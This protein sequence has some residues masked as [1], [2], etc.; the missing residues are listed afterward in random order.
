VA[1]YQKLQLEPT[2]TV[3]LRNAKITYVQL[4]KQIQLMVE[5]FSYEPR[6]RA[7]NHR[8]A[9]RFKFLFKKK[10]GS[11]TRF[12]RRYIIFEIA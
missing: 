5:E 2:A 12:K 4:S 6:G 11:R 1:F 3:L 7:R 10:I 9:L 8:R